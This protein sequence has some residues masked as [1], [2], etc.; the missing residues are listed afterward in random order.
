MD[1]RRNFFR[2]CCEEDSSLLCCCFRLNRRPSV[3]K[4]REK[5]L[6]SFSCNIFSHSSEA[7]WKKSVKI[8][9]EAHMG[10]QYELV[11]LPSR[12]RL[13]GGSLS[14]VWA[15]M[16]SSEKCFAFIVGVANSSRII[17]CVSFSVLRFFPSHTAKVSGKFYFS[18]AFWG[19]GKVNYD[20][21]RSRS[22]DLWRRFEVEIEF[23][24][25]KY[26]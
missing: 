23:K 5:N 18:F 4:S 15:S 9:E 2:S 13:Q 1:M 26:S 8:K 19:E 24:N 14:T 20:M 16:F 22:Q 11:I 21:N 10:R 6:F 3:L 12:M 17:Y 25:R 7:K